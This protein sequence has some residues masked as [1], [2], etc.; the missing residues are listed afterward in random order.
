MNF[1]EADEVGFIEQMFDFKTKLPKKDFTSKLLNDHYMFL[2]P[3]RIR[4]IV[5]GLLKNIF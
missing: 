3:A 1:L 5:F 4:E 2:Q